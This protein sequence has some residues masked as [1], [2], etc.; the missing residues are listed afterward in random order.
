M[1]T[2]LDGLLSRLRTDAVHPDLAGLEEAVFRRIAARPQVSSLQQLSLGMVAAFGAVLL[3]VA[4]NGLA[5]PA[6][7]SVTLSPFGP[8]NP[9]APS[10]LLGG[11]R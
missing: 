5:T 9:L 7:A 1:N 4:S 6:E 2:D 3:G 10:T 11:M 8:S